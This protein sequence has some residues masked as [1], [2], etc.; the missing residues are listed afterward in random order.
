MVSAFLVDGRPYNTLKPDARL[1]EQ[2]R[3]YREEMGAE[4]AARQKALAEAERK[5][6][7]KPK[8]KPR[9]R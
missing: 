4:K 1:G 9:E 5:R 3:R 6:Q 2:E 8:D 7:P